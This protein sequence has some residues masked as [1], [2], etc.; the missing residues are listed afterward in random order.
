MYARCVLIYNQGGVYAAD[1]MYHS[2]CMSSYILTFKPEI[3][4]LLECDEEVDD[5]Y[6]KNLFENLDV[7]CK[8]SAVSDC[9]DTLIKKFQEVDIGTFIIHFLGIIC[10]SRSWE[11]L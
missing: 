8:S 5:G 2:N 6:F 4:S 7:D 3:E 11:K 1:V 10:L 9:C